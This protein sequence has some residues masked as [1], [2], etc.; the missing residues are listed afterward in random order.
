MIKKGIDFWCWNGELLIIHGDKTIGGLPTNGALAAANIMLAAEIL[1]LGAC[2]LGY[3]THF[4]NVSK[5]IREIIKIP[6][7]HIE[8]ILRDFIWGFAFMFGLVF[9][10][11]V[12]GPKVWSFIIGLASSYIVYKALFIAL[13]Y[14][15]S[16]VDLD[17][18]Y[19]FSGA[20]LINFFGRIITA[21]LIYGALTIHFDNLQTR[22]QLRERLE[23]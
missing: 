19:L 17:F 6:S 7:L 16:P 12:W 15:P 3:L 13:E 2:S 5:T 4:I 9:A 18:E 8:R 10:V 21:L 23:E 14:G 20:D 1:G 22:K 11:N